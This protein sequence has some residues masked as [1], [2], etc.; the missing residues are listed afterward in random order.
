MVALV[1]PLWNYDFP[2]A[3]SEHPSLTFQARLHVLHT[4]LKRYP[5]IWLPISGGDTLKTYDMKLQ[6]IILNVLTVSV[7][8]LQS[9]W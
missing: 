3:P 8:W 9:D 7:E 1:V 4:F 6:G 5:S 2:G